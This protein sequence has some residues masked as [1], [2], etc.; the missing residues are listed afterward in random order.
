MRTGTT[1]PR[2]S[3]GTEMRRALEAH[4]SLLKNVYHPEPPPQAFMDP[5]A[6]TEFYPHGGAPPQM[7][8]GPSPFYN[9]MPGGMPPAPLM[10]RHQGSSEEL[11]E[12]EL[13]MA[14]MHGV[15]AGQHHYGQSSGS[16]A[17]EAATRATDP[18]AHLYAG[19]SSAAGS[20]YRMGY[21]GPTGEHPYGVH[22]YLSKAHMEATLKA[23]PSMQANLQAYHAVQGYH[24]HA[25]GQVMPGAGP[26]QG[27]IPAQGHP[28]NGYYAGHPGMLRGHY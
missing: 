28:G 21:P 4:A 23:D 25:W 6:P 17:V 2:A 9:L 7:R 15:T 13:A 27:A 16:G 20:L 12:A 24:Q 5:R 14:R 11:P 3:V 26:M 8:Y 19:R 18:N 22:P 10:A 1:R